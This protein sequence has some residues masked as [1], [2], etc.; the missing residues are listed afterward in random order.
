MSCFPGEIKNYYKIMKS[1]K[2]IFSNNWARITSEIGDTTSGMNLLS[3]IC[4]LCISPLS[5]IH[6]LKSKCKIN[7]L[8]S[9]KSS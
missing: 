7:V 6:S 4:S 1:L 5:Q 2:N 9:V 3:Y 8:F